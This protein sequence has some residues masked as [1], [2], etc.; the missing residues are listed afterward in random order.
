MLKKIT[1]AFLLIASTSITLP[2]Q[3]SLLETLNKASQLT[4]AV[5]GKET[6]QLPDLSAEATQA[7]TK[8]I[9]QNSLEG[10]NCAGLKTARKQAESGL[11]AAN[12]EKK[13]LEA[14]PA[15]EVSTTKSAANTALGLAGAFMKG[16]NANKANAA[17]SVLNAEAEKRAAEIKL[18]ADLQAKFTAD[19]NTI[20]AAQAKVKCK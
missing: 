20:K 4:G 16:D 8:P 15:P 10:L 17:A 6:P 5:T 13:R 9:E 3:A 11:A 18:Q 14:L 2:A 7:V 19:I 1:T 12:A